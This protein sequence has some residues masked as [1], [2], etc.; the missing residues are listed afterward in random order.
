MGFRFSP[1]GK[2]NKKS[3]IMENTDKIVLDLP[4]EDL[5]WIA[6]LLSRGLMEH[7]TSYGDAIPVPES[8]SKYIQELKEKCDNE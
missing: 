1:S 5:G 8:I 3:R 7:V 2:N 4:R 6:S